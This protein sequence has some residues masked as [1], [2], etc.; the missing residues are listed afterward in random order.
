MWA[1]WRDCARPCSN[2]TLTGAAVGYVGH[3]MTTA[4]N[5]VIQRSGAK[6]AFVTNH[7]FRDLLLIGRQ[8]RPSLFDIDV[9]RVPPLVPRELSYGIVGRL[10]A[11]G[12]EIEPL[13]EAQL[14]EAAADMRARDVEAVAVA[15]LHAYANPAH[16]RAA[17][18]VLERHLPGVAVC[19]S[20]DVLREFREFER[21][22]TVVLNAFLTPLME[23]YLGSLSGRLHD[24]DSGL[25]VARDT[26]IMVMEAAGGLMTV[27]TALAKP[28]HTL[29]SGPAGG[30]VAGAHFAGLIGANDVITMDV[31]GTSTDISLIRNGR[32]ETT[33]QARIGQVPIRLPTIDINAIGAGG[34][35]IAWIDDG[36]A[37]RVGPMSAE[38]VPGPACYGRGG[39]KPTTSDANLVLGRLGSETRLG[40]NLRLDPAAARDAIETH[41]AGPLG[42]DATAAAVG[43]LRVAHANI[44]R[45]IRVVSVERGHDPRQC[46]LVPFGGAGPMHGT[47]VARELRIGRLI[48]PPAPGILCA[49]G[50]LLADL[51]HDLVETHIFAYADGNASRAGAIAHR[52][53]EEGDRLLAA[54]GVATD[55]RA[56]EVRVE[57]RYVGQSYEL[58]IVFRHRDSRRLGP[59]RRRFPRRPPPSVRTRRHR[60]AHRDRGA[61]G[62]RHRQ[63][64]RTRAAGASPGR[65]R[66]VRRGAAGDAR[67]F[68]RGNGDRPGRRLGGGEDIRAREAA[69]EQHDRGTRGDRG[70]IGDHGPLP[71][72]PCA[73][74]CQRRADRGVR[75][76]TDR[77]VTF[78]PIALEVLRNALEATAQEMGGVLKLTSF[79]PNIK[80]R[81]DASCAIFDARAQLIAQAEHVPIHLGSMLKAVGPTIAAAG[82]LEPGDVVIVNDPFVGGAH[83][84]DI[85]LVAPVYAEGGLVGYVGDTRAPFR[86][87]RDGA[88]FHARQVGRDLPGGPGDTA[89]A[90]LCAR[91]AAGRRDAHDHGQC[92]H[93]H[94]KAR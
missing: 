11:G 72:R 86:R 3:G 81:M 17:K 30:V 57:A 6:T 22:S 44:V 48:V 82:P 32:P 61:G 24:T 47:P 78:D 68:L 36:G 52:L 46:T 84:P 31:G 42:I 77:S 60:G 15:F 90:A 94:G 34:G 39:T 45:G 89:G 2:W 12:R 74:A 40:G 25:G 7:G 66:A 59:H 49:L 33:R 4:T 51:R 65:R 85:T 80:E 73:R 62:H 83:L 21:A 5:A 53:A 14:V 23:R 50:Q 43:I 26:P 76:M 69:R 19:I 88:G 9:V 38:A 28:V 93:G 55:K 56:I 41:V 92:A 27:E 63:G 37:L 54:D 13:D 64:R 79:S 71:W 1:P 70:S 58:P 87:R 20:S 75:A 91:R 35:S 8:D 10:D 29:L 18:A 67:C 16:E